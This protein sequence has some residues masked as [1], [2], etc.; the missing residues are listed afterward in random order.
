MV[1][2]F[3][4]LVVAL[5]FSLLALSLISASLEVKEQ[6]VSS[7]AVPGLDKPAIFKLS[8]KN[9]GADDRFTI[10]SLVGIRIEP[11]MS[12]EILSGETKEVTVNLYPTFPLKISPDYFSFEYQ[13]KG[14]KT[15][16]QSGEIAISLVAPKDAFDLNFEDVNPE[17]KTAT[18][19]FNNKYGGDFEQ[20]SVELSSPLFSATQNFALSA[21]ENKKLDITLDS[22]KI[23]S[24]MAGQYIVDA[25]IK[26]NGVSAQKSTVIN[27]NEKAGITVTEISEG[28]IL[29][30]YEIEKKNTGNTK[31]EVTVALSRNLFS[32]LFTS[33]NLVPAKKELSGFHINYVFK[34]ELSPN[35]SLRVVAKTN[36]WILI[37]VILAVIIIWYLVDKYLSNK[38]V[39]KK[40]VSFVRTK[41]GE[42]ALKVSI[43]VK[44]RDFVERIKIVD[45]LPPMVKIFERYGMSMPEKIDEVN[46]RL[47]WNIQALSNGEERI[48]SYIIYS[49]I[50]VM[51]RFELPPARAIYEFQGKIKDSES[52]RAIYV[53]ESGMRS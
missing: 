46:R 34:K 40:T 44:A 47:E 20:I 48:L 29:R 52:N 18:L 30:R 1:K 15:P 2:K 41:G 45:R 17:S 38:I 6:A 33:F 32:A 36:W 3:G 5:F 12:T 39:M 16:V 24:L 7:M 22:D 19:N 21:N 43:A 53:N 49:K 31:T 28:N 14:E 23:K 26:V 13:I 50:G 35:E 51:G 4:V 25:N 8:I 37:G 9:L 42:F 11:N 10:Y 27:F